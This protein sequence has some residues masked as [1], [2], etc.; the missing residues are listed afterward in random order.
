VVVPDGATDFI[1]VLESTN[2]K[3]HR[4]N[5]HPVT[6]IFFTEIDDS[7]E[8]FPQ[9]ENMIVF[10]PTLTPWRMMELVRCFAADSPKSSMAV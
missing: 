5:T 3:G 2:S 10:D 8:D 4:E 7:D 6:I 9:F 1:C